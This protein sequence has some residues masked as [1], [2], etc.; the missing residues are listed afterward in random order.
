MGQHPR[1]EAGVVD[2]ATLLALPNRMWRLQQASDRM[3]GLHTAAVFM[4]ATRVA[5]V[6]GLRFAAEFAAET[7]RTSSTS[8]ATTGSMSTRTCAA[9]A[10]RFRC[11]C[12]ISRASVP[13]VRRPA[14]S[15]LATADSSLRRH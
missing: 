10:C 3:G 13:M 12:L 15:T 2:A 6:G 4:G 11:P 5:V 1:D 9:S 7:R 8:F 14:A